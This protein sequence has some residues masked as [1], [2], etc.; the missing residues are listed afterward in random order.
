VEISFMINDD[1]WLCSSVFDL[2]TRKYLLE[3]EPVIRL[4]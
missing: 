3:N 1:K 2:K 4:K